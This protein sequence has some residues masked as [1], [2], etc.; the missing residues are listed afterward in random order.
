MKKNYLLLT[1]LVA[2]SWVAPLAGSEQATRTSRVLVRS[3]DEGPYGPLPA[4]IGV[5]G[6]WQK[7]QKLR[8]TASV[9]YTT[10][11]PDDEQ[12]GVLTLLSRGLGV[13]TAL[14]TLNRGEGGAN[15]VGPE[16]FDALGLIR[17]EELRLAGRYYGLDDQYFTT[18]VDYGYSKTLDEALRSWDRATVLG[19]MVRIIRTNRPLVMISRFRGDTSDGHGHHQ[20]AGV[21]TSEAVRAA[22]DPS[23]FPEQITYDGLRPWRVRKLYRARRS[24]DGHVDA[25]L[26]PHQDSPWLG[27][28]YQSFGSY[29]LSLQRS[30]TTGRLRS[31]GGSRTPARYERLHL[32][33]ADAGTSDFGNDVFAGLDTSLSGLFRLVNERGSAR[34]EESLS[35]AESHIEAA[36]VA[37]SV[38][39]LG[40]TAHHLAR[41]RAAL[42]GAAGDVAPNSEAAFLLEIERRE[43]DVTLAPALGIRLE[44]L[45][46]RPGIGADESMGPAVPGQDLDVHVSVTVAGSEVVTL[47]DVRLE[48]EPG[49]GT[50]GQIDAT[51]LSAGAAARGSLGLSIALDAQP[52]RPWFYRTSIAQDM[53]MVRDAADMHLGESRPRAMAVATL[54]YGGQRFDV[55]APIRTVEPQPPYGAAQPVLTV[56]PRLTVTAAP[57][58]AVLLPSRPSEAVPSVAVSIEVTSNAPTA[59]EADVGLD[60]PHGWTSEP[61]SAAL[62]FDSPGS[63]ER[64]QFQ[65]FPPGRPEHLESE[66]P[67]PERVTIQ[68]RARAGGREYTEGFQRIAH[69]DLTPTHLYSAAR[70]DVIPVHVAVAM[71]LDAGYVMGVGDDVPA[72]IE[73]LGI[74]LR[75]LSAADLSGGDLSDYDVIVVGTR[76]YSVRPDLIAANARLLEYARAG[77]NLV[78]LYQTQEYTPESQAPYPASLPRSAQEVSEQDA[79][80]ALLAPDHQL[81][82]TPNR[83]GAADFD[84]WIEQRG[85]KFFTTWSS[86]YTPLIETHD[87]GQSPQRGVWLTAEV[88]DGHFTYAAIALH[89]QLPYGVPGAY[90]I[91]ANLLSLGG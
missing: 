78:V 76:A 87:T 71:D 11:H 27:S 62:H 75:L 72:A 24:D 32:P 31:G 8:T 80:V 55:R 19:D 85:S 13:R 37:F 6:A 52:S 2:V 25:E 83:I 65:V 18:A 33:D 57:I 28:T 77:G 1:I 10:P 49:W 21:L 91:L 5:V 61:A 86:E 74:P 88:G 35:A 58:A 3:W 63:S 64:V 68:A 43:I 67:W 23:E 16:L 60:L 34:A 41:A 14:L 56:A 51:T 38:T 54:E 47:S 36:A 30:Q 84:G 73:Q 79:P 42:I 59:L 26:N 53:Y 90:R 22:A 7:L 9:L 70:V 69:R 44:A 46:S 82:T 66:R 12:G 48:A 40:P 89:R 45:A 50:R 15:A 20:A 4:N 39:D 81:L 17:S 29:G